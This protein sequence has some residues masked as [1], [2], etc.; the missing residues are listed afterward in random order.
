MLVGCSSKALTKKKGKERRLA[1]EEENRKECK[2]MFWRKG[3]K[4]P[5]V[6]KNSGNEGRGGV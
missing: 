5:Q 6:K 3:L 2:E 4:D 1:G